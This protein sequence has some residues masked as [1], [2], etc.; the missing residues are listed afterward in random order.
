V[1]PLDIDIVRFTAVH[2]WTAVDPTFFLE[3]FLELGYGPQL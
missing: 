1:I 3:R 2:L